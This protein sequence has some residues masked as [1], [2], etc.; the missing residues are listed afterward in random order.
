MSDPERPWRLTIEPPA[1]WL[2]HRQLAVDKLIAMGWKVLPE[3]S[4]AEVMP[5]ESVPFA[6]ADAS[7]RVPLAYE[8]TQD[9][10]RHIS[11]IRHIE[12]GETVEAVMRRDFSE[13]ALDMYSN[14]NIGTALGSTVLG[15]PEASPPPGAPEEY[16]VMFKPR[17][18]RQV[19]L[20]ADAATNLYT[21]IESGAIGPKVIRLSP[22]QKRLFKHLCDL[23]DTRSP[24]ADAGTG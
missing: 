4:S 11:T 5:V 8:I 22:A 9:K 14:T 15:K 21:D 7:T 17:L 6:Q 19:A 23:I 3:A 16:Y 12:S 13:L 10:V 20:R 24:Q 1:R 2:P 18:A